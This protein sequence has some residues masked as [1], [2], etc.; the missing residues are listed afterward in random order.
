MEVTGL[1]GKNP[2]VALSGQPG[3]LENNEVLSYQKQ[4]R[5]KATLQLI[6]G[7]GKIKCRALSDGPLSPDMTAMPVYNPL[8][9][10]QADTGSIELIGGVKPLK[11]F[12]KLIGVFRIKSDPIIPDV[13]NRLAILLL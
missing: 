11:R 6:L 4:I 12:E 9:G 5:P 8:D 13:E 1:S 2:L 3:E 7:Q 10:G